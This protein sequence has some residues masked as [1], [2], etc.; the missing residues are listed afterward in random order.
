MAG[1]NLSS[2]NVEGHAD[3]GVGILKIELSNHTLQLNDVSYSNHRM[4]VD[5]YYRKIH[6]NKPFFDAYIK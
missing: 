4:S 2:I 6:M 5:T 1:F 3:F